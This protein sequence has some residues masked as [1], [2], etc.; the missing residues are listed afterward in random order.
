MSAV[1][2]KER[3]ARQLMDAVERLQYDIAR[4]ELWASALGGFS[5]PVPDYDPSK[6]KLDQFML[7][8]SSTEPSTESKPFDPAEDRPNAAS[9]SPAK[10]GP[11]SH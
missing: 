7:P 2:P 1:E 3:I 10:R 11:E 8:R 4:V 6:S 9:K 5:Q